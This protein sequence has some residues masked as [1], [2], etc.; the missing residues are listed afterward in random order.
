[1]ILMA[2]AFLS[3]CGRAQASWPVVDVGAIAKLVEQISTMQE[4][5]VTAQTHLAQAQAQFQSMTGG[6]GMERLLAGTTR[7]YLPSDWRSLADAIH[8][9]GTGFRGL[10]AGISAAMDANAILTADQISDLSPAERDQLLAARR[11]AAM[12]QTTT[13]EALEN[14]SSRFASIQQLIDA[15]SSAQD[16]K[17]ILDLQARIGA[18]Q[19]MLANE[20]TKLQMIYQTAQAEEWARKQRAQERAVADIGSFRQL[21]PMGLR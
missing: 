15:I 5:L 1:M 18:E 4:Q 9:T 13:H 17:A 21:P 7:N 16:Q 10:S 6:R 12:L 11:S 19:G 20:H 3:Y 8:Q 14:T 2:L